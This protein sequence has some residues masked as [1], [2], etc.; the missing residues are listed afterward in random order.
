MN[1]S[2][3]N[4]GLFGTCAG[5]IFVAIGWTTW[6]TLRLEGLEHGARMEAETQEALRLSLWRM[7]AAILP[8]LVQE[9][10]RPWEEYQR[11]SSEKGLFFLPR[12]T[13]FKTYFQISPEGKITAPNLVW[14]EMKDAFTEMSR[15]LRPEELRAKVLQQS[16]KGTPPDILAPLASSD[17][18]FQ[19]EQLQQKGEQE[20]L[21]RQ[22][23][24]ENA[25]KLYV[26]ERQG[27]EPRPIVPS[28]T[29]LIPLWV[30][31][32]TH[33]EPELFLV[34]AAVNPN[35]A[36]LQG[37]WADWRGIRQRLLDNIQDL[38]PL[39]S[40]ITLRPVVDEQDSSRGKMLATI[41]VA[42]EPGVL[43]ENR[44][45]GVTP[46]R[47]ILVIAWILVAF[48]V[49]TAGL[50]LRTAI[51]L[52]E[53]RGRFVSAVTHELRTPLTTFQLYSQM[54]ADGMV[55]DEKTRR[56]YLETLKKES[57]RLGRIVENVLLYAR[58]E[59]HRTKLQ[60]E[61]IEAEELLR[62]VFPRLEKRASEGGFQ[63]DADV[64]QA[65]GVFAETDPQAVEQILFNL[66][67]NSCKY[68]SGATDRRLHLHIKRSGDGLQIL[69]S[70]HGPGI[71]VEETSRIFLPFERGSKDLAGGA[72]GIGLGLT[73]AR[74]MAKELGGDLKLVPHGGPGA[75]FSL[76]LPTVRG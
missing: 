9:A 36:T 20:Y 52:G 70:D 40:G 18:G 63:L 25:Q 44:D 51:E 50:V 28:A 42:L 43:K 55:R 34:R 67:D 26:G 71:P 22:W 8:L 49:I 46:L 75:A 64:S 19:Q 5:V 31:P 21:A 72:P 1:A 57:E 59:G 56:E 38:F 7:D 47:M 76:L 17:L 37:I 4:W 39:D 69:Y 3:K 29:R 24:V 68:A 12:S 58:V 62:H 27:G 23:N 13:D 48:A 30:Q 66:V 45:L 10:G 53:R 60:K 32:P 61:K 11:P 16:S 54:L 6:N 65:E 33:K 15:W 35:G 41:P 14:P 74:A 73:L 2:K